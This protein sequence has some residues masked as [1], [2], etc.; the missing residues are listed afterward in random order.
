MLDRAHVTWD[1]GGVLFRSGAG[2]GRVASPES[3]NAMD[4]TELVG[5]ALDK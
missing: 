5:V 1:G 2:L 4:A 3:G